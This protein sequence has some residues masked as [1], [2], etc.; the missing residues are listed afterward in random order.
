MRRLHTLMLIVA[1]LIVTLPAAA[2]EAP[3]IGIVVMH[4]KGGRPGALVNQLADGLESK[5]YKVA[6]IEMPWSG[7]RAYDVD[8]AGADREVDAAIAKLRAA[9]AARIFVAGHSQG[10]VYALHYAVK[11]PMDGLILIAPGGNVGTRF[12]QSKVGA[13]VAQARAMIAAGKGNERGEFI[14]YEGSKPDADI[15][16]PAAI[17]LTWFDPDGA[18][19]Q[20]KSSEALPASLPVLYISPTN[21]YPGLRRTKSEMFNALPSNPLTRLHEPDATHRSAPTDS[22]EEIARWVTEVAAAAKN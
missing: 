18:M 20:K 10:G 6:N 22:L 14:D 12:Y 2:Q 7:K 1:A 8:I 11:H 4:G 3:R 19:N 9:G 13:S 17:Y 21:D 16:T 5:G 15:R